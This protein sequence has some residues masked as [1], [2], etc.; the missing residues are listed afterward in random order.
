M[1]NA[2]LKAYLVALFVYYLFIVSSWPKVANLCYYLI[3]LGL[4]QNNGPMGMF[5]FTVPK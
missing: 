5:N 4:Q 2:G 1:A 3:P